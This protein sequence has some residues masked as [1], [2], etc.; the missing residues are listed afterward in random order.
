M[1]VKYI[2]IIKHFV[3]VLVSKGCLLLFTGGLDKCEVKW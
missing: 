3:I 1:V 2:L